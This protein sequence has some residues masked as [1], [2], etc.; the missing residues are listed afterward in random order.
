MILIESLLNTFEGIVI[1]WG[2]WGISENCLEPKTKPPQ[3]N[4]TKLNFF[5]IYF[6][7]IGSTTYLLLW[8][9]FPSIFPF[10]D[11]IYLEKNT[12]KKPTKVFD[13]IALKL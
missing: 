5:P 2:S 4:Q 9:F 11:V 10:C 8:S 13:V 1:F 6:E 7:I 12:G 3:A